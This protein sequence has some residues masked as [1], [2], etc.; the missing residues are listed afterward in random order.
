MA[1]ENDEEH[2]AFV[3]DTLLEAAVA[4]IEMEEREGLFNECFD[5]YDCAVI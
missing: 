1:E 4:N 5:T 3:F 2:D